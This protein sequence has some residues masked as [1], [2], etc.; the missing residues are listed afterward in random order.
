MHGRADLVED[1]LLKIDQ[2]LLAN[3][4]NDP[5]RLIFVGDY[6]DRGEQSRQVIER[7][8]ALVDEP[9]LKVTCVKGNHEELLLGFL[10]APAENFAWLDHG[11]LETLASYGVATPLKRR[12]QRDFV[13]LAAEFA[14]KLGDHRAFLEGLPL[15][16]QIGNV[17]ISHA[18]L[19]PTQPL[20]DQP[21]GALLWGHPDF[22][23]QG[24][25]GDTVAIHGHWAAET[26]DVGPNR[27]GID[28]GAYLSGRLTALGV[29]RQRGYWRLCT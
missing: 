14:E 16:I 22:L 17:F 15:S 21:E 9:T 12:C 3:P 7:L 13:G 24:A 26:V 6:V 23:S 8:R 20:R 5:V 1:I 27:I 19:D 10:D 11:G 25:P 2:D 4:T 29:D 28:T 18:G